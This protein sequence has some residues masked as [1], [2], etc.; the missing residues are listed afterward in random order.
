MSMSKEEIIERLT[1]CFKEAI[2]SENIYAVID[3]YKV[4]RAA[5]LSEEEIRQIQK[6]LK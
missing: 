1:R 5:G 3:C 2:E 6:S 4:S